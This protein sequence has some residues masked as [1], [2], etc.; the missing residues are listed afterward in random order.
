MSTGLFF[1]VFFLDWSTSTSAGRRRSHVSECASC[2]SAGLR[3]WPCEVDTVFSRVSCFFFAPK[4][5]HTVYAHPSLVIR[6]EQNMGRRKRRIKENREVKQRLRLL[7]TF[8]GSICWQLNLFKNKN[9][10]HC[11]IKIIQTVHLK[12]L[13]PSFHPLRPPNHSCVSQDS[14][15]YC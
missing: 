6:N 12:E 7:A 1:F 14:P 15:E 8:L 10:K 9:K 11:H 3:E 5:K 2:A 13:T 4:T